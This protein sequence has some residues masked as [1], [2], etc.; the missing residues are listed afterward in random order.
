MV[1]RK[2]LAV[3]M[4]VFLVMSLLGLVWWF[5]TLSRTRGGHGK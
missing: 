4:L 5:I 2:F 3:L 1:A